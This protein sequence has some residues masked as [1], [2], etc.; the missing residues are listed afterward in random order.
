MKMTEKKKIDIMDVINGAV[1][2]PGVRIERDSFLREQF[3][4]PKYREKL[5]D[6]LRKGPS[7]A[8]VSKGDIKKIAEGV[9]NFETTKV[10]AL[11]AAAGIPGGFAM[12][13]T[14]PADLAQFYA[15]VLRVIQELMYL[16]GWD[17]IGNMDAE[18][19]DVL[20]IFLGA[21]SGVQAAEKTVTVICT[22]VA[23]TAEKT[24]AAKALTKTAFYPV[25]KSVAKQ[26]GIRM[27]KQIFAK[28]VS[29][30]VPVIGAVFSGG[31]TFATFKPM[32]N[33]LL[34]L[35]CDKSYDDPNFIIEGQFQEV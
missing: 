26:L 2:V 23:M 11:S 32:C 14:V 19:K 21:M 34:K 13:G 31:L 7:E 24:I 22:R 5:D 9:I 16:Y 18:T 15:H 29:K 6:I 27:T 35:M 3:S 12:F 30:A 25:V 33:K 1:K 28:G 20:L 8:G 4:N 10:T 17:D